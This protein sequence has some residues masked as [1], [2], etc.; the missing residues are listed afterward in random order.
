MYLDLINHLHLM[1]E[2]S[3]QNVEPKNYQPVN[4]WNIAFLIISISDWLE[5]VYV[6]Q[7]LRSTETEPR[8]YLGKTPS[9]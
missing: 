1:L 3:A 6:W 9:K 5:I 4:K 2:S 7:S 8:S